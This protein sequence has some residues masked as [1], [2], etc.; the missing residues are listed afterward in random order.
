MFN[1]IHNKRILQP[2]RQWQ[3]TISQSPKDENNI[4]STL[5]NVFENIYFYNLICA[6]NCNVCRCGHNIRC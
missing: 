2:V 1:N 6:S 5:K 4:Y 3:E